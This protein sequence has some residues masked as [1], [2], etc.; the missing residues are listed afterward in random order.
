MT[1]II[2]HVSMCVASIALGASEKKKDPYKVLHDGSSFLSLCLSL[3][4]LSSCKIHVTSSSSFPFFSSMRFYPS[5]CHSLL[6]LVLLL[7]PLSLLYVTLF[8]QLL[9][10]QVLQFSYKR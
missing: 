1:R 4:H 8:F 7:L 6:F 2:K 10:L 5:S 9:H 3:L